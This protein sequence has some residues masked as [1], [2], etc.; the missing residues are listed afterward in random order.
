VQRRLAYSRDKALVEEYLDREVKKSVT[1]EAARKLYDDTVKSITPE[2]EV[3]ARH[4]LVESEDE[5]KAV[6]ARV[7][8]G[9]DFNKVAAEASKDPGSKDEGGDLGFFA[10]D[11][12]VEPFAEAAFKLEPGQL[13][14]PVKTQFGWHVIKVEEKRTKPIPAFEEM[15]EQVE[16]YLGRKAQQDLIV[17]LRQNAKVERLDEKG[18]LVEQKKP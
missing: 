13:S 15:K 7:K 10:K 12:M 14:D 8:G 2:P 4:I 5:A 11:R 16:A 18:N 1:A 3:R 9:E 17:G 6:H